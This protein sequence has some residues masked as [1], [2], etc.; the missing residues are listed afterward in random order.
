MCFKTPKVKQVDPEEDARKK[1]AE[2]AAKTNSEAAYM[3]SKSIGNSLLSAGGT[4]GATG[5][6]NTSSA[7]AYGKS[8][9]G[10]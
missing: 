1:A 6:A 4:R 3:K 9:L 2:A 7:L 8:Q 5:G 10:S